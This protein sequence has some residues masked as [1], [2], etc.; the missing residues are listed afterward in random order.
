MSRWS[1]SG[2]PIMRSSSPIIFQGRSRHSDRRRLRWRGFCGVGEGQEVFTTETQRSQR[3]IM[4]VVAVLLVLIVGCGAPEEKA[5]R[6]DTAR[7]EAPP[8]ATPKPPPTRKL[9]SVGIP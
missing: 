1:R 4:R 9:D 2:E 3:K 6:V 8:G 5:K 7:P